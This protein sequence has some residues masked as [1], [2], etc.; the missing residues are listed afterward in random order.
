[1]DAVVE[2][3]RRLTVEWQDPRAGLARARGLDGLA[4]LQAMIR[5]ELPPAPMARLLGFELAEVAP[6]RAVFT[7]VP[8]ERHYNPMATVHGGLLATLCDSATG[9]AVFSTCAA[10]ELFT[11]LELKLNFVKAA[12]ADSGLI[13]CEATVLHRGGRIATAEAR[14]VDAKG[15]LYAHATSTCMILDAKR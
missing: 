3:E 5:G 14:A 11:T 7:V 4:F 12:L 8:G 10:G 9:C 15:T 1:M 6:G 13:R 2:S